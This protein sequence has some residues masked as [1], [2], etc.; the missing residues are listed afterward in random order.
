MLTSTDLMTYRNTTSNNNKNN[1]NNQKN[2]K[3]IQMDSQLMSLIKDFYNS[4]FELMKAPR[5]FP[6][7]SSGTITMTTPSDYHQIISS[8][9]A[10]GRLI[11]KN[12]EKHFLEIIKK[13]DKKIEPSNC[14][15]S[16]YCLSNAMFVKGIQWNHIVTY[17]VFSAY[18]AHYADQE[19]AASVSDVALWLCRFVSERLLDWI[20]TNGGWVKQNYRYRSR[21]YRTLTE[22]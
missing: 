14:C 9:K 2:T 15:A 16:F 7:V 13:F 20:E 21:L 6:N 17:F 12:Y 18:F 22:Q 11:Q 4:Q 5:P 1:K 10:L 19:D 8:L 3:L